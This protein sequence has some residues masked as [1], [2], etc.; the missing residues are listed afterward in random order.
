MKKIILSFALFTA[1]FATMAQ[2]G[3]GTISPEGALD[4]VST[5]SGLILPRV[6]NT[7]A[8]TSPKNGMIVYDLSSH[9]LRAFTS[10][11]SDCFGQNAASLAAVAAIVTAS[12]DPAADG[13][14][15][16]AD[17]TNAGLTF[18][19]SDQADY[20]VAIANANPVPTTLTELQAIIHAVNH[21]QFHTSVVE[22]TGPNGNI[23]MDRNLGA[24]QAA[25]SIGDTAAYGDYYQ[26]GRGADGHEKLT[27]GTTTTRSSGDTPGHGNFITGIFDW[28]RTQNDNLWQGVDGINNPCPA[29]YRV[30]TMSELE[31][32]GITNADTAL[33]LPLKL[34]LA[35]ARSHNFGSFFDGNFFGYYWSSSVNGPY[36][37]Y[38]EFYRYEANVSSWVIRHYGFS[39]RCIKD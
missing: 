35:G 25:T 22:V 26:W 5:N 16:I 3:V 1:S 33:S 21:A 34:P 18:L 28:R 19:T 7:A 12:T 20:E 31:G 23:W 17:L 32:L 8:V 4:V 11:W 6:A 27:S 38:L 29:G 2:I 37:R 15:S 36:A 24:T 14:P 10:V 9:C 13:T 30:P 39:V